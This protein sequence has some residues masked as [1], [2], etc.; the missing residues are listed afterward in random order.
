MD[1][2]V[3]PPKLCDVDACTRE[4]YALGKCQGHYR[5]VKTGNA[6]LGPL[7]IGPVPRISAGGYVH[8]FM[9]KHPNANDSGYIAEHRY[10]MAEYLGRPLLPSENVHHINGVRS[11]N[12]LENLE[13]WSTSQPAGQRVED[14][15]QWAIEILTLYAPE[16]LRTEQPHHSERET[17]P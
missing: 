13:L 8:I 6:D 12:R 14:K 11:D 5:R 1:L 17:H 7:R 15:A 16:M 10:S 3:P 9:P 4:L 2:P